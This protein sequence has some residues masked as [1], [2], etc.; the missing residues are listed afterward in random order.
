MGCRVWVSFRG[1][2]DRDDRV[3]TTAT[4]RNL[5]VTLL[6]TLLTLN[7]IYHLPSTLYPKSYTLSPEPQASLA[8]SKNRISVGMDQ[9]LNPKP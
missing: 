7:P 8:T 4:L 2:R 5:P 6:L 9:T 1:P 3:I